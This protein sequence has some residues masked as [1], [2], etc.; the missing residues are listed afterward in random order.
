MAKLFGITGGIGSG[1][2]TISEQLLKSGYPVFNTDAEAQRIMRDN[3]AVRSQIEMLF[4]SDIYEGDILNKQEVARQIFM[5]PDL[6]CKVDHAVHP[7]VGFELKQWLKHQEGICFVESAI[8]FESGLNSLCD[9]V[10]CVTAPLELRINRTATRDNTTR[11]QVINKINA[12]MSETE[13]VT[14][15][16]LNI[17]NDGTREISDL[18]LAVLDFCRNFVA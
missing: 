15:S 4:G 14:L 7:A 8:L 16:D 11:E 1:K 3:L 9:A 2:T 10:I 6:R 13:K 18:C 12:Q 5:Q 17:A